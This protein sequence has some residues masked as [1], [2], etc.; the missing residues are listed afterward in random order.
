MNPELQ[1][2]L[3]MLAQKFGTSVEHLYPIL[4]AK[5]KMDAALCVYGFGLL[6]ILGIAVV[7]F[8]IYAVVKWKWDEIT[9]MPMG[10]IAALVLLFGCLSVGNISDYRYP[11]A[12]AMQKILGR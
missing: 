5:A 4:V 10:I 1:N 2:T 7:V 8:L 12:A 9:F 3:A 11:E 6:T